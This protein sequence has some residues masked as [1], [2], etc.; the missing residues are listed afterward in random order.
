[1]PVFLEP[2]LEQVSHALQQNGY[3]TAH[4]GKWHLSSAPKNHNNEIP[5]PS[6]Y[7]FDDFK[8]YHTYFSDVTREHHFIRG[9]D[10]HYRAKSSQKIIDETLAFLEAN[11]DKPVYVNAWTLIP[12]ATLNPTPEQLAVYEEIDPDPSDFPYHM[13]EYLETIPP[14]EL[15]ERMQIYCA[16]VTGLDDAVGHLLDGIKEMGIE[17]NT[18]IFFTS[19]NGP[20]D[21]FQGTTRAGV[22]STGELR[23]RKRS[24]YE[25]G[26]RT[27]AIAYW[28]GT[29]PAGVVNDTSIVAAVDWFPTVCAIT[30]VP[31]NGADVDG[32][33]V[34]DILKGS[35]RQRTKPIFWE[36]QFDVRGPDSY[37]APQLAMRDG[38]WK[39][40]MNPDGSQVELYNIPQDPEELKNVA[41]EN[42]ARV[43]SMEEQLLEWKASLPQTPE[44]SAYLHNFDA[45]PFRSEYR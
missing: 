30:G 24:S 11:P 31:L 32:E 13:R 25:G 4:Y 21:N 1:M 12:H 6:F 5:N 22:G 8:T 27:S 15:K 19:D 42:R 37:A 45:K 16:A 9:G 10:E 35:S 36:W 33:N 20:E 41:N 14:D 26:V 17:E 43:Q 18:F 38:D 7:G 44:P 2:D 39:M 28:P 34:S 40:L 23:A 29:I 3:A